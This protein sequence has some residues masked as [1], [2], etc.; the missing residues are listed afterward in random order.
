[1]RS[2][3]SF[4]KLKIKAMNKKVFP[5]FSAFLIA[6]CMY[7]Q[8]PQKMSYQAVIRNTSNILVTN[9]TV[10]MQISILQGSPTGTPVYVETQ[11]PATNINGLVSLE[12]GSGTI[13]SGNFSTID[14]ST[15]PYFIKTE[16]DPS[17]ATNYTITGTSQLLSVPYALYAANGGTPGQQGPTGPQGIQGIQGTQGPNGTQGPQGMQ[18]QAGLSTCNFI[19]S[20]EGRIVIYSGT[21]AYGF[22]KNNT[23]GSNWYSTSISGT[24]IGAIASDSNIVI[25]TTTNAYGFGY[26]STSGSNW[27]TTSLSAAPTGF[28]T[29]SGRI[30]LYNNTNAYGFGYNSTSGSNWYTTAL[31]GPPANQT[32]AGNRIVLFTATNAYGFGFN[33]TSG[34]NWYSTPLT[35]TPINLIGT[36]H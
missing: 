1:M 30:V 35:T 34:S 25:Y 5:F 18:G 20:G 27:Y 12:V 15:G 33:S 19:L 31:S 8:V 14:W 26:N 21:N 3:H 24:F 11:T 6:S 23:S 28:V 7:A 2:I 32:G 36:Q 9:T 4:K 22:G 17:G 29:C 10:G 16:T 13:V